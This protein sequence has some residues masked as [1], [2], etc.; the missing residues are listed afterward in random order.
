MAGSFSENV[1]C[2]PRF[3]DASSAYLPKNDRGEAGACTVL[4]RYCAICCDRTAAG[5]T[6]T[7]AVSAKIRS[8]KPEL[9]GDGPLSSVA[10]ER[11]DTPDNKADLV[12]ASLLILD[13]ALDSTL[14]VARRRNADFVGLL[15][16]LAI[17]CRRVGDKGAAVAVL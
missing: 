6:C 9:A 1:P 14:A 3:S 4:R 11:D 13:D 7:G 5:S 12:R 10:A 17:M 8:G 16:V 15:G 2:A